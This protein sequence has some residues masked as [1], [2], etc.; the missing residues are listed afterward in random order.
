MPGRKPA[1]ALADLSP[2][3]ALVK[4]NLLALS[5]NQ[6]VDLSPLSGLCAPASGSAHP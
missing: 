3:A 5:G 2:L 4:L 6:V 1:G